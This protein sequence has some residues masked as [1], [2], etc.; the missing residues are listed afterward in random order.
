MTRIK[1]KLAQSVRQ[2]RCAPATPRPARAGTK[3]APAAP[4]QAPAAT[5]PASAVVASSAR[6]GADPR[7]SSANLFPRRVWPD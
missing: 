6:G 3:P 5:R 7:E 2:A 4:T 1:D